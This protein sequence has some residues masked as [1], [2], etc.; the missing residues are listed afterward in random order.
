[1]Y[2]NKPDMRKTWMNCLKQRK[3]CQIDQMLVVERKSR[4]KQHS[5]RNWDSTLTCMWKS[6]AY[7]YIRAVIKNGYP[8]LLIDIIEMKLTKSTHRQNILVNSM[9]AIHYFHIANVD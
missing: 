9:N 2:M 3:D 6:S 5:A 8:C 7:L 4:E 1:M